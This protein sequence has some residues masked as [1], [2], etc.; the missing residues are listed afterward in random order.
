MRSFNQHVSAAH[1][2]TFRDNLQQYIGAPYDE[3]VY[4]PSQW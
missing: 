2:I 3:R 4:Q 1:T